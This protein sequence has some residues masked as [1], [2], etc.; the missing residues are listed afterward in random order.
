ME[1]NSTLITLILH[2]VLSAGLFWSCFCRL[3]KTNTSTSVFLRTSLI[4]TA[5]I[6]IAF[7]VAPFIWGLQPDFWK[8]AILTSAV[9]ARI[10]GS[11]QWA[12]GVPEAYT[13]QT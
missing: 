12:F 5:L 9:L 8:N 13:K 6:S 1:F 11:K 10:A 2:V 7:M 3:S 4:F